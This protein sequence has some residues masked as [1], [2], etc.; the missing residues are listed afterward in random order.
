MVEETILKTTNLLFFLLLIYSTFL[1]MPFVVGDVPPLNLTVVTDKSIYLQGGRVEISGT[2]SVGV[3]PIPKWPIAISINFPDG[4]TLLHA[5]P[6]TNQDGNFAMTFNLPSKTKSGTYAVLSSARWNTMYSMR[7]VTFEIR[8]TE[9]AGVIQPQVPLKPLAY[10]PVLLTLIAGVVAFSL[11]IF[12]LIFYGLVAFQK[13][14]EA[15]VAP[16]TPITSVRKV[17]GMPYKKCVKCGR[18]FLGVHT[19]C[20]YCFTYHGKNGYVEKTTV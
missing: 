13:R 9:Q 11:V 20:P 10:S 15:P 5:T 16:V 18:T 12:A 19:F 4:T 17:S 3:N 6:E 8:P 2:L 7:E 1:N 14:V